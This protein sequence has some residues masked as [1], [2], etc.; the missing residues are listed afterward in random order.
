MIYQVLQGLAFMHRNG[1]FHRDMKP[2]N[3]LNVDIKI[4][5]VLNMVDFARYRAPEVLLH[6]TNYG[7]P[8]DLWA[9]GCIMAELYTFRPLFPGNSEIDEIFKICSVL[10]TPEKVGQ[11]LGI[12]PVSD[13]TSGRQ[14][15]SLAAATL[16]DSRYYPESRRWARDRS[17][18][19]LD[20]LLGREPA[21]WSQ[22][23]YEP[24]AVTVLEPGAAHYQRFDSGAARILHPTYAYSTKGARSTLGGT[25]AYLPAT[26]PRPSA[27]AISEVTASIYN[28]DI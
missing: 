1:F 26:L 12:L 6:A 16:G 23:H 8:I 7:S 20:D 27:A 15:V 17:D 19:E 18:H 22:R 13:S 28:F 3:L 24:S 9:V 11:R 25:K 14:S 5:A 10:G 2:E 4:L 21:V